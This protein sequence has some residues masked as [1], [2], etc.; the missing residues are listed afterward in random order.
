M[1]THTNVAKGVCKD[2]QEVLIAL[3]NECLKIIDDADQGGE[4]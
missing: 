4:K 2:V 1:I 3:K